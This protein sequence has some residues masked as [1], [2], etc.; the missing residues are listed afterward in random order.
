MQRRPETGEPAADDDQV[1]SVRAAVQDGSGVRAHRALGRI[2]PIDLGNGVG[3]GRRDD[4][5]VG[6]G[7][8]VEHLGRD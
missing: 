5:G 1:G 4:R 6:G 3:E 7:I 8:R 2:G